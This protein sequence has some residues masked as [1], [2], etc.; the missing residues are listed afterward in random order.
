MECLEREG[1]GRGVVQ[2]E[3]SDSKKK[4]M[5][6]QCEQIFPHTHPPLHTPAHKYM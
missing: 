3:E 5:N 2:V 6:V 1:E 4:E